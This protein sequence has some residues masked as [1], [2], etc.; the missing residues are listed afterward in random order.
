[1]PYARDV[2]NLES[3]VARV[4]ID[5]RHLTSFG[6]AFLCGRDSG[7]GQSCVNNDNF[8]TILGTSTIELTLTPSASTRFVWIE[9]HIPDNEPVEPFS[10][11]GTSAMV[12]YRIFRQ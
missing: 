8:P 6:R 7:G 10:G 2:D 3:I 11:R 4:V 1:V 12:G 9:V 5:D